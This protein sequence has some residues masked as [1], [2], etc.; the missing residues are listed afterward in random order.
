MTKSAENSLPGLI[1]LTGLD[2]TG[3]GELAAHLRD[4]YGFL[5]LGASEIIGKVKAERPHLQSLHPDEATRL[6]KEELGPTFITDSAVDQ[7]EA[8]QD[9]YT[10]L[11]LDGI[12][13]L[14]EI[15]RVKERGG[16]VLHIN[17]SNSGERFKRLVERGRNDAP[18]SV[19]G[20]LA[21]DATQLDGD[22]NDRNSLNMRAII[23][24]ADDIVVNYYNDHFYEDA[25]N[26]LRKLSK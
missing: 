1:A 6:L 16:A 5:T 13:R 21:R 20:M 7:F 23:E 10:G 11:V 4:H 24:L 14:P 15:E 3:K 22:P 9:H 2:G 26:T 25:I 8:S 12:R 18:K 19:E 17:V